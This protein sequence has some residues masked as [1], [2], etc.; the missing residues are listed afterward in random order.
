[1]VRY[2]TIYPYGSEGLVVLPVSL[3]YRDL[4]QDGLFCRALQ[5]G[6]GNAPHNQPWKVQ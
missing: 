3:G 5:P 1:M 4:A 6:R 2:Y